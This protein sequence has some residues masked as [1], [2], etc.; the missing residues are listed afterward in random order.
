MKGSFDLDQL[1]ASLPAG[2]DRA[3][4]RVLS[5]HQGRRNAIGR[6]QLIKDL[7]SLGFDYR[8][9]DRPVRECI[10][11]MRKAGKRICSAGGLKGGYWLA[12]D[13]PELNDFI[14]QELHSRAMDLLEQE[15]AL[16][17]AAEETWGKFAPENQG[18]LF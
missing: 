1:I 14:D 17:Q 8:K 18:R 9:D 2:L 10:N 4:L 13:W 16:R 7:H 15:R 11:L 12:A 3:I 6:K 5:F